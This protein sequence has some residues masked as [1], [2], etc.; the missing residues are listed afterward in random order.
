MRKAVRENAARHDRKRNVKLERDVDDGI[1][2][3]VWMQPDLRC[4]LRAAR[5]TLCVVCGTSYAAADG[6]RTRVSA[7]A[8]SAARGGARSE[9]AIG[10]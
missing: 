5:C 10:A 9:D 2:R 1:G 6:W 7:T 3:L 4:M 8:C